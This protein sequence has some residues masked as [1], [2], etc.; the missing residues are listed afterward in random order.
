MVEKGFLQEAGPLKKGKNISQTYFPRISSE[1]FF[2][3]I[4]DSLPPCIDMIELIRR[5]L[6]LDEVDIELL[7]KLIAFLKK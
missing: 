5:L 6:I 3:S 4:C 2:Q 1:Q 7:D